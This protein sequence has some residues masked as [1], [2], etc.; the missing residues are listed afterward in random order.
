MVE[1]E[2]QDEQDGWRVAGVLRQACVE[3]SHLLVHPG[4]LAC[5]QLTHQIQYHHNFG[6]TLKLK[7]PDIDVVPWVSGLYPVDTK[8]AFFF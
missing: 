6:Q 8:D 7:T 3:T 2:L 1:E 5:V 4:Y